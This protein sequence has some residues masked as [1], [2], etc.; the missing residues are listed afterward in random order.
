MTGITRKLVLSAV[1]GLLS[2]TAFASPQTGSIAATN[3][4]NVSPPIGSAATTNEAPGAAVAAMP[5][6]T[7]SKEETHSSAHVPELDWSFNG[8]FGTYDPA[9]LQ[10]GFLV[11]RNVC[12]ACHA[13]DKMYYRHLAGIG[14][15]DAQIKTIAADATVTDG[16]NDEGEM[17][18]R[19]GRPSD[20]IKKPFLND[21]AAMFANNGAL[22]PDLSLIS[23]ARHGGADYVYGIL[24][25]YANPPADMV[26]QP[27]QHYNKIKDGH[28]IAMAPPLT[29]GAVPYEDGAPQTVQQYAKD[30]AQFLTWA[31]EPEMEQRKRMGTKVIIFL[32]IFASVMYAT[33]RKIW[34]N[35]H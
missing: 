34:Q 8:P 21:K 26:L 19:P 10:R 18:E 22:P 29:D 1:I 30:V 15:S 5:A 23:K 14:Y 35:L 17:F 13:L 11:Y 4:E 6:E 9:A 16:P 24:T 33:K 7:T 25:G 12:S 28:I 2:T 32:A 27:G 20:K 31:A 3:A